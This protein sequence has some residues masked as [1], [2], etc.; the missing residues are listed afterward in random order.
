MARNVELSNEEINFP[1]L[2]ET[3]YRAK[4]KLQVPFS[5]PD[6]DKYWENDEN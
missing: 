2:R 1:Y 4:K 3:I 6:N 5:Y